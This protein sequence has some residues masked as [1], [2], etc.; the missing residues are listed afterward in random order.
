MKRAVLAALIAQRPER[1]KALIEQVDVGAPP[2]DFEGGVVSMGERLKAVH[3]S[4]IVELLTPYTHDEASLFAAA[5]TRRVGSALPDIP[6]LKEARV[7]ALDCAEHHL[8]TTLFKTICPPEYLAY[9]P[10]RQLATCGRTALI[11][12]IDFLGLRDLARE[13][14]YIVR[15]RHMRAIER[16]FSE[17]Q[18]AFMRRIAKEGEPIR[19]PRLRID[20]WDGNEES[21]KKQLHIRGLLRLAKALYGC[22][23]SLLWYVTRTLDTTRGRYV[24]AHCTKTRQTRAHQTLITQVA[25]L[26]KEVA[27]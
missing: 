13:L 1:E 8:L 7:R 15:A 20:G 6:A 22:E 18:L 23:R 17:Q 9:H 21:L 16:S 27:A 5:Y 24:E 11:G 10:L 14:P 25:E 19:F 2:F 12:V 26:L 4:W 3:P